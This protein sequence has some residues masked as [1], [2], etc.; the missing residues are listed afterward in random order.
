MTFVIFLLSCILYIIPNVSDVVQTLEKSLI[1][2]K[3]IMRFILS[4]AICFWKTLD[5]KS[6]TGGQQI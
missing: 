2:L 4:N 3:V 5:K 1:S 6:E